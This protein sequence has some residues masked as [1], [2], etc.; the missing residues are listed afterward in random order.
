LLHN[1]NLES[2]KSQGFFVGSEPEGN[3]KDIV[4]KFNQ[5]LCFTGTLV[6]LFFALVGAGLFILRRRF[7][8]MPRPCTVWGY[9]ITPLLFI[10]VP[11]ALVINTLF[12][13]PVPALI[14]LG[15]LALGIAVYV[16]SRRVK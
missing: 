6:W 3:R 11:V 15:L 4:T 7:P 13:Y 10:L 16:V 2:T 14:G 9:P 5:L 12:S 1:K 8:D